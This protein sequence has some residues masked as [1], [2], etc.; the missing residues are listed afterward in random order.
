MVPV[1]RSGMQR[2][3]FHSPPELR[4]DADDRLADHQDTGDHGGGDEGVWEDPPHRGL[5]TRPGPG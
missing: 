2:K 5:R 3:E 4:A 1:S